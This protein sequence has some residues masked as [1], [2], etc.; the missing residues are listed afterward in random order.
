LSTHYGKIDFDEW[1]GIPY[2]H[3]KRLAQM[4]T[5]QQRARRNQVGMWGK[6]QSDFT[7]YQNANRL[8]LLRESL[9]D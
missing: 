1:V 4:Q 7:R 3:Y 8:K 5:Q 9:I 6:Y 2:W